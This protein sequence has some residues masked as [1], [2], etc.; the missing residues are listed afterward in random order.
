MFEESM[1]EVTINF[2]SEHLVGLIGIVIAII[3]PFVIHKI[4]KR[5]AQLSFQKSALVLLGRDENN[6]PDDVT[7]LFKKQEV[8]RL[9]KITLILWNSGTQILRGED[10]V[11]DDSLR[12]VFPDGT[13]ILS[14][15]ILKTTNTHNKFEITK[16][17]D[18]PHQLS[19]SLD[20]LNPKDGITVEVIH[21]S[22][23]PY[24]ELMGT[25][26]GI[27]DGFEDLGIIQLHEL[28]NKA[29]QSKRIS[30]SFVVFA[31]LIGLISYYVFWYGDD[32]DFFFWFGTLYILASLPLLWPLW[33][34]KKRYPKSLGIEE[35]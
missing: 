31:G 13:N 7:I 29:T 19:I 35:S 25:I 16:N 22:G 21:D 27:P 15:K 30:L 11:D 4:F 8:D 2:V 10:I 20:Y 23:E 3:L 9:T 17:E 32:T 28:S 14:Y 34:R 1:F 12:I 24:P 26:K 6:L 33:S 18:A 5:P